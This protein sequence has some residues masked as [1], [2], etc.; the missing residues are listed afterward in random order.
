MLEVHILHSGTFWGFSVPNIFDPWLVES[1][2]AECTDS[3]GLLYSKML[4]KNV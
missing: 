4:F 1:A 3:D 2:D